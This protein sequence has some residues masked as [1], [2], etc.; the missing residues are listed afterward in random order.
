MH[1]NCSFVTGHGA[2]GFYLI[3]FALLMAPGRRRRMAMTGAVVLG[4]LIGLGRMMQGAH[5]LSDVVFA[6]VFNIAIAWALYYWIV[7][8]GGLSPPALRPL[9]RGDPRRRRSKLSRPD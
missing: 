8:R 9:P 4:A 5:W 6:G 7:V 2:A 3:T 1:H